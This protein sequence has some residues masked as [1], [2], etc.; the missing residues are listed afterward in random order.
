MLGCYLWDF[1]SASDSKAYVN[2]HLYADAILQFDHGKDTVEL[3]QK[4]KWPLD[5]EVKFSLIKP[6]SL[7]L[8][9]ILRIPKWA[10]GLKVSLDTLENI[11]PLY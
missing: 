8:T 3:T 1:G 9:M 5:G 11:M 10:K 4:N 2:V 7:D 6:N